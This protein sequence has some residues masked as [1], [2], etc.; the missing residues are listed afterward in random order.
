MKGNELHFPRTCHIVEVARQAV[1]HA[2]TSFN[3]THWNLAD[4][5]FRR[6]VHYFATV[7]TVDKWSGLCT[8]LV[9]R[10]R[11]TPKDELFPMCAGLER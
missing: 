3:P 10:Q 5:L 4:V 11:F 6:V 8:L 2:P 7:M 9:L 1:E